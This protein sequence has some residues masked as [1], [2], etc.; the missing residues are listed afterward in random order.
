MPSKS[1][2]PD[3]PGRDATRELLAKVRK[4]EIHTRRLVTDLFSGEYHSSFRGQGMEFDEVRE[5]Q[6]GDDVRFIDWNV[7]A[8]TGTPFIKK[9]REEREMTVLLV[10]DGSSSLRFGSGAQTKAE[11]TA[12][13]AAVLAFSAIANQD[14]VGLLFFTDRVERYIAP[15][16]GRG[17]VLR[18]IRELLSFRPEHDGSNLARALEH[19]V[20]TQKRRAVVFVV[21]DFWSDPFEHALAIC[22]RKHDTIAVQVVDPREQTPVGAGL[23][24]MAD[25]ETGAE[26]WVDTDGWDWERHVRG[27]AERFEAQLQEVLR[28]CNTDRVAI[29]AGE[30]F[31]L[32]LGRFFRRRARKL[33]WA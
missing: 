22:A 11:T 27:D 33:V 3:D 32:A 21:S 4:I 16:K 31:V 19:V 24:R 7:T 9:F 2:E 28:R 15:Q 25:A 18:L 12:E 6:P 13:L 30:P 17:H 5:Y 23:V 29:V 8:R 14:K 20:R 26:A 10:V 1:P